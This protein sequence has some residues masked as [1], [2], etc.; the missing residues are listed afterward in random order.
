ML[1][2][3]QDDWLEPEQST[4]AK[5]KRSM[6][7]PDAFEAEQDRAKVELANYRKAWE[8]AAGL[9]ESYELHRQPNELID[10]SPLLALFDLRFLELSERMRGFALDTGD[11]II[12]A[13]NDRLSGEESRFVAAHEVGH[14]ALW[15]PNSLNNCLENQWLYNQLEKEASALAAFLLLPAQTVSTSLFDSQGQSR[16]EELAQRYVV[17][18]ELILLRRALY[19]QIGH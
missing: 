15:H 19:A 3:A 13:I 14:I 7:T 17:P 6:L 5:P 11:K 1:Y 9:I 16:V 8:V 18:S 2:L 4:S 12:I 10:L